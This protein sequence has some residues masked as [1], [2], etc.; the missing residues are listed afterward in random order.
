MSAS[1]LARRA[2]LRGSAR[3]ATAVAAAAGPGTTTRRHFSLGAAF[4]AA[5]TT[6]AE[7]ITFVHHCG[8]PW[9]L[10]IPLVAA[11]VNFTCRLPVYWYVRVVQNRRTRI[12]PLYQAWTATHAREAA[13]I[14]SP[15]AATEEATA[16][17]A[18]SATAAAAAKAKRKRDSQTFRMIRKSRQR[19]YRRFDCQVWKSL[20]PL[21]SMAPFVM[22]TDA[23]RRLVG[24]SAISSPAGPAQL[25]SLVDQSIAEGGLA[26]FV[27]LTVQDPYMVLPVACSVAMAAS[28]WRG[29]D[30]KTLLERLTG[31]GGAPAGGGLQFLS[32]ALGR[33]AILVPLIPIALHAQPA[34]IFLYW[35]TTFSLNHVN[36][37]IYD[38]YLP[39][40]KPGLKPPPMDKNRRVSPPPWLHSGE[41]QVPITKAQETQAKSA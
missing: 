24:M 30:A 9:Y 27:D 32:G 14:T 31:K 1:L 3:H 28:T 5:S 19:L 18:S 7:A 34:A 22:V 12:L 2:P 40:P 13:A 26:W 20:T 21:L 33:V 11:T 37:A 38:K 10:T 41:M 6:T 23:L 8:L 25:D 29:M 15:A 39:V 35:I 36:S 17:A 4:A 16:T